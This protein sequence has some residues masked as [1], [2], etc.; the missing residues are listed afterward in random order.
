M[1]IIGENDKVQ[2]YLTSQTLT[3]GPRVFDNMISSAKIQVHFGTMMEKFT[4][5]DLRD[6]LAK[7]NE[8]KSGDQLAGIA[9]HSE[10]ERVAAKRLLAEISLD[11]IVQQP[12]ID[13][14]DDD[15]SRLFLRHFRS[16]RLSLSIRS[17]TVGEFRE[18]LL[19][20]ATSEAMLKQF[21]VGHHCQKSRRPSP[22]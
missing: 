22:S 8:E 15:V 9:A 19:D 17:M 16:G 12:L 3:R 21:A 6:L 18:F 14:L 2:S 7:A 13:P 20:D 4:F 10:R 5:S 1:W 11:E